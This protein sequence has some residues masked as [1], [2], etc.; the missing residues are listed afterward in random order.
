VTVW[1]TKQ[2]TPEIIKNS[3][4]LNYTQSCVLLKKNE[5][6]QIV[7]VVGAAALREFQTGRHHPKDFITTPKRCRGKRYC[8]SAIIR[9]TL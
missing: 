8:R 2:N 9:V 1:N 3:E 7:A 4:G 6:G 5:G